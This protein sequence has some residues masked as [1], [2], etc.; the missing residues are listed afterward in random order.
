MRP[1]PTELTHRIEKFLDAINGD[2]F[3]RDALT[4]HF[5]TSFKQGMF[6]VSVCDNGRHTLLMFRGEGNGFSKRVFKYIAQS[7]AGVGRIVTGWNGRHG[8]TT[9]SIVI[10]RPLPPVLQHTI[11]AYHALPNVFDHSPAMSARYKRYTEWEK[12]QLERV[13]FR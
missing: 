7:V 8:M 11:A 2:D 3:P 5:G 4:S 1:R 13:S 9:I 12:R 6:N 10:D